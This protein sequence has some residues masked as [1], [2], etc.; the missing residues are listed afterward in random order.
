[1]HKLADYWDTQFFLFSQKFHDKSFF[2]NCEKNRARYNIFEVISGF[3][4]LHKIQKG[5]NFWKSNI[6]QLTYKQNTSVR[7]MSKMHYFEKNSP[8]CSGELLWDFTHLIS[9]LKTCCGLRHLKDTFLST[10]LNIWSFSLL[11]LSFTAV[12]SLFSLVPRVPSDFV[13]TA[14]PQSAAKNSQYSHIT[15]RRRNI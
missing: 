12:L 6:Q 7:P 13:Y 2:L 15:R 10:L 4:L 1:M 5:S 8:W 3:G 11:C 14:L 9:R